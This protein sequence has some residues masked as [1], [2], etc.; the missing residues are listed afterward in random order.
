MAVKVDREQRPDIDQ[1]YMDVC[2]AMTGSG[3]WP[4]SLLPQ[5]YNLWM[6]DREEL[7]NSSEN[8]INHL[9]K[10][11]NHSQEDLKLDQKLITET[12]KI[13][14]KIYDQEYAGFGSAPKFPMPHYLI[15]LLDQWQE[16]SEK[17]YLEM[18][19]KSLYAMRAGGIFDQLGGG[20]HRYST[21][22]K[23]EIP[24]FEKMLYDQAL[25]IYSYAEAYQISKKNIYLDTI[26]KTF[27]SIK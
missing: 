26:N 21:D 11:Q 8:I 15:F 14:R 16:N 18:V 7:L 27:S 17:R 3:G 4:L 6:N 24:H 19:E 1:V 13:L 25:L 23:W 2:K 10:E 5:I 22:P 9:K 12:L 20:F